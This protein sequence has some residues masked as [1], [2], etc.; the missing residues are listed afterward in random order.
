MSDYVEKAAL[1]TPPALEEDDVTIAKGKVRVRALTRF[2]AGQIQKRD[3]TDAKDRLTLTYG[4]V[5]PKLSEAE[6]GEWMKADKAGDLV[7]AC[8]RIAELSGLLESSGTDAYKSD[9]DG[10]EPGV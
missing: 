2:E 5:K 6:A 7:R 9:G 10:S 1:L 3:D 4:M 8:N